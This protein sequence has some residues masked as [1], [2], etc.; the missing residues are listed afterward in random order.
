[1]VWDFRFFVGMSSGFDGVNGVAWETDEKVMDSGY[2]GRVAESV[3]S[4][5]W[6]L[7]LLRRLG[8]Q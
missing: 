6:V 1:M 7:G 2:D 5:A 8:A 3:G 4:Q